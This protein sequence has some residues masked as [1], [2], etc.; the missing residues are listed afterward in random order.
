MVFNTELR[1]PF[2][3]KP[4]SG[5]QQALERYSQVFALLF[6]NFSEEN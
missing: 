2:T 5:F 1:N 6:D 4:F 3:D